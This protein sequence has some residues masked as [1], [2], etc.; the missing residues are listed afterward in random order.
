MQTLLMILHTDD[1]KMRIV[2]GSGGPWSQKK[3]ENHTESQ[4]T[5][6]LGLQGIQMNAQDQ[7]MLHF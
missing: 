5:K 1:L 3:V 6:F 2:V 7:C 4:K